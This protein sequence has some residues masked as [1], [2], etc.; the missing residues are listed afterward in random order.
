M[1]GVAKVGAGV[2]GAF[3]AAGPRPGVLGRW[4]RLVRRRPRSG[5]GHGSR[6]ASP[7]RVCGQRSGTGPL[8]ARRPAT[9]KP[10]LLRPW[11]SVR[12]SKGRRS[13]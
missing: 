6:P 3:G 2:A 11:R 8:S 12:A 9:P 4:A 5:G 13:H 10:S 1:Y 7:R